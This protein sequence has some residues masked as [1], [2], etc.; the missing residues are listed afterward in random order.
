MSWQKA[1]I[2]NPNEQVMNSWSG[3]CERHHK[4]VVAQQG[5][6]RTHYNTVEAKETHSGTLVLT[7]QRHQPRCDTPKIQKHR[8]RRQTRWR[9]ADARW[10]TL[11]RSY[12]GNG[13][14]QPV[15]RESRN[16]THN[17]KHTQ[18]TRDRS[19]GAPRRAKFRLRI[20]GWRELR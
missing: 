13:T 9:N 11:C 2:L 3:N 6:I 16:A 7:N 17:R 19:V 1:I 18:S 20:A 14:I 4:K 8:L 10:N 12:S 15:F 5:L